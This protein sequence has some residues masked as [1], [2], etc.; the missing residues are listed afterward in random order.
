MTEDAKRLDVGSLRALAH[1]LRLRLLDLLRMD[2]PATATK[3][4]ER[5]G[6]T[7]GNVSWHLRQL[8]AAGFIE[9]D[10]ER[11]NRRERWWRARHRYTSVRDADFRDDPEARRS[12]VALKSHTLAQQMRRAE[13]FLHGDWDDAW[14]D[15]AGIGHWVLRLTPDELLALGREVAAVLERYEARPRDGRGE[16]AEDVIVQVQAFPRRR[17]DGR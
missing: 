3:L 14:H 1:P 7:S 12:L 15:A 9:E 13:E 5:V 17:E 8:A 16:K 10:S 6:E 4:A 11:G 2:G